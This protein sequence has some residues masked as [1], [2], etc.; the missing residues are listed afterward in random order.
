MKPLL[1]VYFYK[2]Y[3]LLLPLKYLNSRGPGPGW[4][5]KALASG[6]KFK[7]TPKKSVLKINNIL[8]QY[9]KAAKLMQ[10]FMMNKI[11]KF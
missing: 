9:P 10:K 5:N 2:Y 7:G 6:E 8:V 11:Q 4:N 1:G 3:S